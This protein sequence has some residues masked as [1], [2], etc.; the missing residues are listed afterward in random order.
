MAA[1][2]DR[3]FAAIRR[4]AERSTKVAIHAP[5]LTSFQVQEMPALVAAFQNGGWQS[6]PIT[7]LRDSFNRHYIMCGISTC[8][9]ADVCSP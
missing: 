8:G 6:A 5:Q 7:P 9:G 4:M 3:F 1:E 2:L